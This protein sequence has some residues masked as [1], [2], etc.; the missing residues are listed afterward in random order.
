M[1]SQYRSDRLSNGD[2]ERCGSPLSGQLE[3]GNQKTRGTLYIAY[4]YAYN[5]T[6]NSEDIKLREAVKNVLADFAR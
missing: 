2:G 6:L 1:R 4:V 5:H 3:Y